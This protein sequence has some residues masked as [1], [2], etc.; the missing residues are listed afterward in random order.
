MIRTREPPENW[1][2]ALTTFSLGKNKTS[3][4]LCQSRICTFHFNVFALSN[5]YFDKN[6]EDPSIVAII[7]MF[8]ISCATLAFNVIK[9]LHILQKKTIHW[10]RVFNMNPWNNLSVDCRKTESGYSFYTSKLRNDNFFTIY[11]KFLELI[12]ICTKGLYTF[13][14]RL[15]P[16]AHVKFMIREHV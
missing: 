3:S 13:G 4:K 2:T 14:R 16:K 1:C 5:T 8:A 11:F 6:T 9:Y 7:A 15:G 10:G 12:L